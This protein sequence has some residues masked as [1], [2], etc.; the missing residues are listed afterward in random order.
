MCIKFILTAACLFI[1]STVSSQ[2][3]VIKEMLK[4]FAAVRLWQH[5]EIPIDW[6]M[7]GDLQIDLNVG[8]NNLVEGNPAIAE[9][10][11]SQ[12]LV[13]DSTIWQAYY[14]RAAARKQLHQLE[15]S[16]Y[17][18]IQVL[19]LNP[20]FP[21]AYI[22]LAKV[23]QLTGKASASDSSINLAITYAKSKAVAYYVKGDINLVQENRADAVHSYLSCLE[24]DP[25]FHDARLKLTMSDYLSTYNISNTLVQLGKVLKKD[26]L[27]KTA[28]L[29]RSIVSYDVNKKQSIRDLSSLIRVNPF[30]TLAFY[31][32]GV[33]Y[34]EVRRFDKAFSDFQTTIKQTATNENY[35]A[36]LQTLLDKKINLQNAG[37]YA[38]TRIYGLPDEDSKRLKQ[39]Y[40]YLMIYNFNGSIAVID[41]TSNPKE[42]L[43]VYLKAVA[44][45]HMGNHSNAYRL[46]NE[47]LKLDDQIADAYKKRGIYEQELKH[48]D[49]SIDDFSAVLKLTTDAFIMYKLRGVSN[50]QL[51]RF[52]AASDDFS[53]YLK[54]DSTSMEV[55][56]YRAMAYMQNK[57]MLEAYLDFAVSR[58]IQM[59]N[60][61]E[62]SKL[63]NG[64]LVKGDSLRSMKALTVFTTA[65][66][67]YTDGYVQKLKIHRARNEWTEIEKALP[68]AIRNCSV[69]TGKSDESYL[70]TLQAMS[71]ARHGLDEQ[72]LKTFDR[73]ILLDGKNKLASQERNKLLV[74]LGQGQ[75]KTSLKNTAA[76]GQKKSAAM[77]LS[78][79]WVRA[80]VESFDGSEI[81]GNH[82]TNQPQ[83]FIFINKEI[84][85]FEGCIE[86]RMNYQLDGNMLHLGFNVFTIEFINDKEI[87]LLETTGNQVR[88]IFIPTDSFTVARK[89]PFIVNKE[90][91]DTVYTTVPGIEPQYKK[92]NILQAWL[93]GATSSIAIAFDYVVQKDGNIGEVT[94]HTTTNEAFSKRFIQ[95]VKKT[96]GSWIP[97]A[98]NGK[99]VSV[100]C[101]ANVSRQ[102]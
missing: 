19:R 101:S 55:V 11:F 46:Y 70:Y 1:A 16:K 74:K 81:R 14:Y 94:I 48:W 60:F 36:G 35:F 17:D 23:Y 102:Y 75:E 43:A 85:T 12:A 3:E 10:S 28:L 83:R 38:V 72:A 77:A 18:I 52:R 59:L 88:H 76:R 32:R 79:D 65:A 61:S 8:L 24:I 37:A 20:K 27:Q 64:L 49:K 21:E 2:D 44:N 89:F 22:E 71:E 67:T 7:K 73:A 95:N 5:E 98:I 42:P 96:S 39:A 100:K 62:M 6:K 66:P 51:G 50:Y 34:T 40:C 92:V 99:P 13:K 93:M 29:F 30:N 26:S 84:A 69:L 68:T 54:Y 41:S 80:R 25:N 31:F 4:S 53:S 78:G 90:T 33:M 87:R 47:A 58:N 91:S 45:E 86:S 9:K 97:G 56:G 82:A 15:Y 57:Q 63:V